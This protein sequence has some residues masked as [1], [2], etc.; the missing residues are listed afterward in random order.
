MINLLKPIRI[1]INPQELNA[2]IDAETTDDDNNGDSDGGAGASIPTGF[3]EVTPEQLEEYNKQNYSDGNKKATPKGGGAQGG[4][5]V[6]T[7]LLNFS[8]D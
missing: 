7:Q 5:S 1:T 8:D 4:K 6:H 2:L 3:V